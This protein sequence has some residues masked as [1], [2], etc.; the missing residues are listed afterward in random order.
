MS[1]NQKSNLNENFLKYKR[2]DVNI[3][4]RFGSHLYNSLDWV[5]SFT[6]CILTNFIYYS[7][8]V[9]CVFLGLYFYFCFWD[10]CMPCNL[11]VSDK[12]ELKE[13]FVILGWSDSFYCNSGMVLGQLGGQRLHVLGIEPP[14]LSIF[15]FQPALL[16]F[17]HGNP[18]WVARKVLSMIY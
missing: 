6:A 7:K 1:W 12:R 13:H 4:V 3:L 11:P 9:R 16:P 5:N 18:V 2:T 8:S 17:S 15:S 10:D 14:F